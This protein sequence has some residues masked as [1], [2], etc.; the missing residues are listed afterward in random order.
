MVQA[1]G[2]VSD[3]KDISSVKRVVYFRYMYTGYLKVYAVNQEELLS[4]P[5]FNTPFTLLYLF[6]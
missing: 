5:I 1:F 4:N 6:V 3:G 2:I